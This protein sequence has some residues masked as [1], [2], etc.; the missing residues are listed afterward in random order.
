LITGIVP[1]GQ[2]PTTYSI[3]AESFGTFKMESLKLQYS[4]YIVLSILSSL[5]AQVA[6]IFARF[7]SVTHPYIKN[8]VSRIKNI[9][10]II[11]II[12]L[13]IY[14]LIIHLPKLKTNQ[15]ENRCNYCGQ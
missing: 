14:K 11:L 13:Q 12:C 9:F 8:V 1:S 6:Q 10:F 3:I 15:N 2:G 4:L 7:F 5:T